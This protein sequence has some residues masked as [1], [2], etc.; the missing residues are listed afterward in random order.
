MKNLFFSLAFMLTASFAFANNSNDSKKDLTIENLDNLK[1][2]FENANCVISNVIIKDNLLC[3]FTITMDNGDGAP[4]SGY[5]DCTGWSS[6]TLWTY[7]L[8]LLNANW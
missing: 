6:D 2:Q 8:E 1:A 7:L 4:Y 5:V 3:G